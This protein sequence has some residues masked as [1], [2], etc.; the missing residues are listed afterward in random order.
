[1]RPE[2]LKASEAEGEKAS[3]VIHM[4]SHGSAV[5]N[6]TRRSEEIILEFILKGDKF[7][8]EID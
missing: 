7:M 5:R 2:K 3:A 4:N 6:L 8:P 1:M